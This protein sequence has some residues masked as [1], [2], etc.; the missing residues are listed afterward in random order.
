MKSTSSRPVGREEAT[1][2]L[3]LMAWSMSASSLEAS[4]CSAP[5]LPPTVCMGPSMGRPPATIVRA[6][7][8]WCIFSTNLPQADEQNAS[9]RMMT[10]LAANGGPAV[11]VRLPYPKTTMPSAPSS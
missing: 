9:D 2:A 7:P 3:N 10:S 6:P 11:V 8:S 1:L 5:R 4:Y